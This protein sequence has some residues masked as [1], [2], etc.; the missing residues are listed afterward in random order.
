MECTEC[1]PKGIVIVRE[2]I[3]DFIIKGAVIFSVFRELTGKQITMIKCCVKYRCIIFIVSFDVEFGEL[4]VP[5][6]FGIIA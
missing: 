6:L 4:V 5:C 3:V 1:I 2:S